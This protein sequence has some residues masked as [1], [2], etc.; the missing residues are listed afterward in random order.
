MSKTLKTGDRVTLTLTGVVGT[1]YGSTH[2]LARS[3]SIDIILDNTDEVY[4]ETSAYLEDIDFE[5]IKPPL[6][7]G[8]YYDPQDSADR[9]DQISLVYK[10]EGSKWYDNMLDEHTPTTAEIAR[11]VRLGPV[12]E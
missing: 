6:Q 1:R 4:I 8:L 11:F 3:D 7:D 2:D 12:Q 9:F 10:L 5:V